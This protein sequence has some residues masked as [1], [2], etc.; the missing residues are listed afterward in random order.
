MD[1]RVPIPE[2][3]PKDILDRSLHGK[4]MTSVTSLSSFAASWSEE[5]DRGWK[6]FLPPDV[7][8]TDSSFHNRTPPA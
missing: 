1:R 3:I 7:I 6:P 2:D 8:A 5:K 4:G